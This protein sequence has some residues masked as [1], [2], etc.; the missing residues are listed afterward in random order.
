MG[1]G[2]SVASPVAFLFVPSPKATRNLS[3]GT[4]VDSFGVSDSTTDA[5]RENP[6]R[7]AGEPLLVVPTGLPLLSTGAGSVM[8]PVESSCGVAPLSDFFFSFFFSV[9]PFVSGWLS[10]KSP[11]CGTAL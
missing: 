6:G 10:R 3:D 9:L 2:E 1:G 4:G 11:N 5:M 8:K 7:G